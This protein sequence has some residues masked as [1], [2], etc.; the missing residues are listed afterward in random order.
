MIENGLSYSYVTPGQAYVFLHIAAEDPTTFYYHLSTPDQHREDIAMED[1]AIGQVLGL[2]LL[3]FKD[4]QPRDHLWRQ[5]VKAQLKKYSIHAFDDVLSGRLSASAGS[6]PAP[7][8]EFKS[9][10]KPFVAR[11][12]SFRNTRRRDEL[13]N[14]EPD[15]SSSKGNVMETKGINPDERRS[16]RQQGQ[17]Q[18]AFCTQQYLLGMVKGSTLNMNCP[19]VEAHQTAAT[20]QH[21]Q[22]SHHAITATDFP[23]LVTSQLARSLHVD[24]KPMG[25]HGARGALFRITLSS[26]GY[27]FVAKGTVYAF[28]PYLLHEGKGHAVPVYL[29]NVNLV[30]KYY[31][32]VRVRILDM[33]LL[34]WGGKMCGHDPVGYDNPD[35][36]PSMQDETWKT[37]CQVKDEGVNQKDFRGST[38]PGQVAAELS[39]HFDHA[40]ASDLNPTHLEVAAHRLSSLTSSGKISLQRSSA[41]E[42]PTHYPSGSADFIAAADP[43]CPLA[44]AETERTI[45]MWFYGRPVFAEAEYAGACQPL[46]NAK[47][48]ISFALALTDVEPTEKAGWKRAMDRMASF[49]DDVDVSSEVWRDVERWKWYAQHPLPFHEPEACGFNVTTS[50]AD[51]VEEKVVEEEDS[52]F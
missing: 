21:V 43:R 8:S 52:E 38:G 22:K 3:A 45:V 19:N 10:S 40:I 2:T 49:L 12:Y 7:V 44:I 29:G 42:I 51:N 24:C 32:T 13:S 5:E 41:E 37:W 4:G 14:A 17:Q 34:L 25:I 36:D 20:I 26:H 33:M 50:S 48:N 6:T 23:Q 46:L 9:M 11:D 39:N 30:H 28:V 35:C 31:L 27:I 16:N 47:L 18:R 15:P 1:T